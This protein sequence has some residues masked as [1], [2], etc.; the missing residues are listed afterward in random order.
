MPY[1]RLVVA[2]LI[3][4]YLHNR[5]STI[6]PITCMNRVGYALLF[7]L[8]FAAS[9]AFAQVSVTIPNVSGAVGEDV[10]VPVQLSNVAAGTSIQAFEFV[11]SATN[12]DIEFRGG[13]FSG[14]LI[15]LGWTRSCNTSINKCLG[16]YGGS[17]ALNTDGTLVNI[18]LRMNA[19][20]TNETVTLTSFRFNGGVPAITPATPSFSITT[21]TAPQASA[22]SYTVAE[23][24][25]L[26]VNAASGVL[27]NDTDTDPLTATLGTSTSNGTLTFNADGSFSY[28]HDGGESSSDAFTYTA[29]DGTETSS[30][31]TVTITVTQVNDTPSAD[32]KTA[33]TNQDTAVPIN[34]SG[35]DPEGSSLTFTVASGPS[36]GT[37]AISGATATYTPANGFSGTDSFTY[38][39]SDGSAT[40]SAAT[41]TI[42]VVPDNAAPVAQNTSAVTL[43]DTSIDITLLAADADSDPLTF[44]VTQPTNG[45]VTLIGTT[46]SYTPD[47]NFNGSDSFTF[48]ANDGTVNSN[49]ATVSITVNAVND[50][51][52]VADA[53]LATDEDTAATLTLS[54]TDADGDAL[55]FAV[56]QPTNGTVTLSGSTATYT[57][58]AGYFGTDSFTYTAND[59]TA[60]SNTGTV[61]VTVNS[62][63]DAPVVAD[64][65]LAT[66]EDTAA[67]LTLSGTDADGDALTFAVTQPANGTVTLSGTT[68]SYTPNAN[69]NGSDSFT[70]T[71]NDGTVNSNTA[72]VSI[73]VNPVNDAPTANPGTAS[74]VEGQGVAFNLSGSDPDGDA[75]TYTIS[76]QPSNGTVIQSGASVS[77]LPTGNYFGTD[78]FGFTVSDGTLTSAEAIVTIT[79]TGTNDAP[80]AQN[81]SATTA[82]DTAVEITL[83]ATD[84]DGDTLTYTAS[85]PA[86]GSVSVSGDKATYTP[87][88]NYNGSDAFTF[89]V[90]DGMETS[91]AT[92]S[93]TITAVNDLPTVDAKTAMVAEDGSVEITLTG[94]D[95]DGDALTFSAASNPTN[96][97]VSISGSTATYTP[98]ADFV[99]EDSF[100]YLANDGTADSQPATVAV[101][102]TPVNDA[103]VAADVSVSGDEDTSITVTLSATDGDGDS[104]TFSVA[105]EPSNGS[106]SISGDV[107]TYTP[108]ANFNGSDSFTYTASDGT[109][110]S[111]EA[112]ASF[113]VN[114]VNDAPTAQSVVVETTSDAS[115]DVTLSGE[116]VDGDALTFAVS[117][118]PIF[119]S[120]SLSGNVATYTADQGFQGTDA[121]AFTV[122]DGT[123]TSAPASV[124][125]QV[126]APNT[127]TIQFINAGGGG[128]TGAL[129]VY[130]GSQKVATGL[131][132][133]SATA[134]TEQPLGGSDIFL[135]ASPSTGTGDAF[136]SFTAPW[137]QGDEATAVFAGVGSNPANAQMIDYSTSASAASPSM[138]DG[139]VVHASSQSPVVDVTTITQ[140]KDHTPLMTV[141]S[142][143]TFASV[144]SVFA[145]APEVYVYRVTAGATTVGEF[146]LDLAPAAG[147]MVAFVI[148]DD[149]AGGAPVLRGYRP[150]GSAIDM[151]VVT[152]V[153]TDTSLPSE[154]VLRGNYPNPFNPTTT[155]SFDLPETGDVQVDVLDLLG[156][157]MMS[158]P[159]QSMSAG[160]NRTVSIDAAD[161]TSG[162][163]MYRVLVRGAS[164]T[165]VKSGTM[166]L[167]K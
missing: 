73:T 135:A 16:F 60:D 76:T 9:T 52:V 1:Y 26:T 166:T 31:A 6:T 81:G 153:Q 159:S 64:A 10:T 160:V 123:E 50:V 132:A 67:T 120:V 56:T 106:V 131:A 87:T 129:D 45:T 34:L 114:P 47:A 27:A 36:N 107:A 33:S 134:L 17:N 152:D 142:G 43:E 21:S 85:D 77:Y 145:Q 164:N 38:T 41:V 149:A 82:E 63:N 150:D 5:I 28:T 78:S 97:S 138:V 140:D 133:G 108:A 4:S 124:T 61:T 92:V 19:T 80:V 74:T 14:T 20:V 62:V 105:T 141:A 18:T 44:A 71:A 84:P 95:V 91:T 79:I 75:L 2:F 139:R 125:I 22:D 70:F 30:V 137:S 161:L 35:S 57:P 37:V 59:G 128:L 109:E 146:Q 116:D 83:S 89:T 136:V 93:I 55:T 119:G 165:W 69:F 94:A 66:D 40:S 121:F 99:G 147:E 96:G 111:A 58:N 122:S 118:D 24:G 90:S 148:M 46:A 86:N 101:T 13:N 23:G 98:A 72:T 102:V 65:I 113:T 53:I 25:T 39:A 126:L 143:L 88:E 68:A 127:F 3:V 156:R 167:I 103:P 162:I 130:Y 48:T 11:V 163:Y 51:P 117:T 115:I 32:N 54:G 49:T 110:S 12:S 112:T 157:S 29:S 158:I 7:S 144:S 154:F 8:F 42:T 100:T 155:I 15:E 104:V 151:G